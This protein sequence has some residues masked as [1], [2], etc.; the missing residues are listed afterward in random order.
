M[1]D[2]DDLIVGIN[3]LL[4]TLAKAADL[5]PWGTPVDFSVLVRQ[6]Q[7][8]ASGTSQYK[9]EDVP[10]ALNS[11][12]ARLNGELVSRTFAEVAT[13]IGVASGGEVEMTLMAEGF[14]VV[15]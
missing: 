3:N 1:A 6:D 15:F 4:D 10:L 13:D 5:G 14:P 12:L 11:M 8:P 2:L 9:V 7:P